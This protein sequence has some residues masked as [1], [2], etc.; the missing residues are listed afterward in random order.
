[1]HICLSWQFFAERQTMTQLGIVI[2][3]LAGQIPE[4]SYATMSRAHRHGPAQKAYLQLQISDT[5]HKSECGEPCWTEFR[6]Q[7]EYKTADRAQRR[8]GSSR[9]ATHQSSGQSRRFLQCRQTQDA[10]A[11]CVPRRRYT[12]NASLYAANNIRAARD[13]HPAGMQSEPRSGKARR[14]VRRS[15]CRWP[16]AKR[17]S[18]FQKYMAHPSE[19]SSHAPWESVWMTP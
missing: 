1:M 7:F 6:C 13:W 3:T 16:E 17:N 9:P 2:R 12:D 10:V 18:N 14:R 8:S 19:P 5:T 15:P 4:R 11:L